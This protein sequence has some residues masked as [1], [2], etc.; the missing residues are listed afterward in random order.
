MKKLLLLSALIATA[1]SAEKIKFEYSDPAKNQSA[2]I[3]G[4]AVIDVVTGDVVVSPS[5]DLFIVPNQSAVLGINADK[6]QVDVGD[7]IS[8]DWAVA[9]GE[10]CVGTVEDGSATG[11]AGSLN[12]GIGSHSKVVTINSLPA[13]LR[14]TCD[15]YMGYTATTTSSKD[16][17][18]SEAEQQ[19]VEGPS[20]SY[21]RAGGSSNNLTVTAA[22]NV[23]VSWSVSNATSCTASSSPLNSDWNH[24]F[25]PT[26]SSSKAVN[27]T[28]S[29]TLTLT[30]GSAT[31]DVNIILDDSIPSQC[32]AAV[33]PPNLNNKT[34]SY[35]ALKDG[36]EFGAT[37]NGNILLDIKN[38][39]FAAITFTSM[40]ANTS[41]RLNFVTPPTTH[42]K[43]LYTTL[44]IS[45]CPGDFNTQTTA[46]VKTIVAAQN[47]NVFITTKSGQ[48]STYCK[49]DPNKAYYLNLVNKQVPYSNDDPICQNA[50]H[51]RCA[52]FFSEGE[53]Q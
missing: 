22:G 1:G 10:N 14:I 37:A 47:P 12:S 25:N 26:S 36:N 35:A 30:C 53:V 6:Y 44:S 41:R 2:D 34:Y 38:T 28:D 43:T 23:T 7:S 18:I 48:P 16:L 15:N 31:R 32:S 4:T 52:A 20:I 29:V 39:E 11:W 27:I 21:L 42:N 40:G 13:T 17:V 49:L 9:Y 5:D 51:T 46:C 19:V 33:Y 45:E 50:S 3:I 24:T 8:V